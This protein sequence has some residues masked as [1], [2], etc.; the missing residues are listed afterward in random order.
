MMHSVSE[1]FFSIIVPVY[2]AGGFLK[3]CLDSILAQSYS[4]LEL[5]LVDD[6]SD[7]GSGVI[8]DEYSKRYNNITVIHK[9]NGGQSLARNI[10]VDAAR[11]HYFIFVDSDD[12]IAV[13]TL[14]MFQQKIDE[15]GQLDVI[16][17]DRMFN[18]EPDGTEIDIQR[19]LDISDFQGIDG[20][21]A[22]IR[23]GMEWSPCGKCYRTK[24]WRYNDFRFIEGIISE[25]FQL[26]DRVTLAADKVAMV[27]AHYYYRWKIE[28]STMHRNY[29]K[30]VRDTIYVLEDWDKYLKE[31]KFEEEL[32][33]VIRKRLAEM[34][35][36]TVM[37]NVYYAEPSSMDELIDGI[38]RNMHLLRYDKSSKGRAIYTVV[39]LIGTDRTCRLLNI[40]KSYR[41]RDIKA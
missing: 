20:H 15:F 9:E 21:Q 4:N 24:F 6:G 18:V 27:P 12:Y 14:E 7:D 1:P 5:I 32:E 19:H 41:K 22:V 8:C 31:Q 3:Q 35:E 10:G 13:N 36:H 33:R 25:D 17:S 28:S 34:F 23:M 40:V 38:S 29:T 2:N 30:L 39:K 37:G 11:G 26:L 16:L